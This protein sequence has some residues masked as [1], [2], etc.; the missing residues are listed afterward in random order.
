MTLEDDVRKCCE[1]IEGVCKDAERVRKVGNEDAKKHLAHLDSRL[2]RFLAEAREVRRKLD[3]GIREGLE[4]LVTAW[5]DG[6]DRVSAHLRLIEAKSTLASAERLAKDGHY[7]AAES[8]VA[9]ALRLVQEARELL[10]TEDAHLSE[11]VEKIE[12][13]I[14]DIKQE[15]KAAAA[16][17]EEVVAA[18][19]RLLA[20]LEH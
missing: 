5:R 3:G 14:Q 11:L 2:E 7:V 20:D 15:G 19:E 6:R 10:G 12:R 16:R 18:N 4:G 17:L 8:A 1:D 13:A 9:S